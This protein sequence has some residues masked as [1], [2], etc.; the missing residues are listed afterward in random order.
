[1]DLNP[2]MVLAPGDGAKAVDARMRV[3]PT[4]KG[5]SPELADVPGRVGK[6]KAVFS[7]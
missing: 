4:A 7:S 2:V 6:P 3:T 5:W 1:M